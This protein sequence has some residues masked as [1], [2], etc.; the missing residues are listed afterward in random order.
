MRVLL[1][2]F[3]AS[4]FVTF[5][6][7]FRSFS[8]LRYK[9][10]LHSVHG[11][12]FIDQMEYMGARDGEG[13]VCRRGIGRNTEGVD[14]LVQDTCG[15]RH[16]WCKTHVACSSQAD[17]CFPPPPLLSTTALCLSRLVWVEG[18]ER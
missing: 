2:V 4:G 16:M 14:H 10:V 13:G 18:D 15:A 7:T 11:R 17:S 5:C 3:A 9:H 6:D 12:M 1:H 8:S